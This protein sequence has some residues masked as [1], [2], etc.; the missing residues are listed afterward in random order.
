[1]RVRLDVSAVKGRVEPVDSHTYPANYSMS[2]SCV[3]VGTP[4]SFPKEDA[5]D[6]SWR[7]RSR[8]RFDIDEI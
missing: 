7:D 1:V 2:V 4:S 5:E 8:P 6:A 3:H